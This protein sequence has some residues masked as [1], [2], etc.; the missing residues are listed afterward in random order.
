MK[1]LLLTL[2]Y[3]GSIAIVAAVGVAVWGYAEFTRPG[4]LAVSRVVVIPR[5]QGLEEIGQTL[6]MAG[7]IES[8]EV[9]A[10]G[11]KLSGTARALKAGEYRFPERVS[12]RGVMD[13]LISGK[14]VVRRLTL[15]EGLTVGQVLEKLAASD[16][17]SGDIGAP[18]EEGT[19]LPETYHF[20]Y[21]DDRSDLVAR[22]R[23]GM[24][25]LVDALWPGRAPDL[26]YKTPQEAVTMASIIEREAAHHDE[27]PVIAGVFVNRLRRGMRL[28]S[29]PTVVYGIAPDGLGRPLSKADLKAPTP[30]NTYVI[31]GLPPGPICNPGEASI[32]A[33][34]NPAKTEFLYFVADGS[35]GHAFARTL[36][37]HNRNVR[38][39]RRQQRTNDGD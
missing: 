17:L 35:G 20:S 4:P 36:D 15:A 25:E 7:V 37:E 29:D 10:V 34:L 9:F 13:I 39:W 2:V 6:S 16:G 11:A 31:D 32:R 19:L 5:G 12:P 28:Q 14:T 30:Y 1:R 3:L 8:P 27:R 23:T 26:P 21:G 33:A 24:R 22:M 18:P 38:R